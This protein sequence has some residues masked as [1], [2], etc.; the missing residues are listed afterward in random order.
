MKKTMIS[1]SA[2]VLT[3]C[4][5]LGAL[6]LSVSAAESYTVTFDYDYNK[7]FAGRM[8]ESG[9]PSANTRVTVCV[10]PDIGY[11][12]DEVYYINSGGTKIMLT[13]GGLAMPGQNNNFSYYFTM[14]AENVT[15]RATFKN[16]S[17]YRVTVQQ[18]D[19]GWVA[20]KGAY[21][22]SEDSLDLVPGTEVYVYLYPKDG[23]VLNSVW[24]ERKSNGQR[25]SVGITSQ[26]HTARFDM[27]PCDVTLKVTYRLAVNNYKLTVNQATGGNVYVDPS[28]DT[29]KEDTYLRAY[30]TE[31]E[32]YRLDSLLVRMNDIFL[33]EVDKVAVWYEFHM[34]S[35]DTTITPIFVERNP[36]EYI[37][38]D[39]NG[40]ILDQKTGYEGRKEPVTDVIP[41][42]EPDGDGEF[43]FDHWEVEHRFFN[44]VYYRPV[45][46]RLVHGAVFRN[47][48]LLETS[49][50]PGDSINIT[51]SLVDLNTE[52]RIARSKMSFILLKDGETIFSRTAPVYAPFEEYPYNI[53]DNFSIPAG[54]EPG[55]YTLSMYYSGDEGEAAYDTEIT[56]LPQTNASI[57]LSSPRQAAEGE[58]FEIEGTVK[59]DSGEPV[60]NATIYVGH[61]NR[62]IYSSAMTDG[63]G[64][65]KRTYTIYDE[66]LATLQA[67]ISNTQYSCETAEAPIYISGGDHNVTVLQTEHGTAHADISSAKCGDIV[68]LTANPKNGYRLKEWEVVSGEIKIENDSF[69]M[70]TQDVE[71]KPVFESNTHT[72][73]IILGNYGNDIT[74]NVPSGERFFNGLDKEGVF[75]TLFEMDTD[76]YI[77]RDLATKPLSEF[78]NEEEFGNDAWEL[79]DTKVND[80]MTVYACFYKKLRNVSLTLTS[81]VAGTNVTVT[82]N[83]DIYIQTPSPV[84][85]PTPDAHCTVSEGSAVW[86]AENYEGGMFEGIFKKGKNYL[87][88]FILSPDFGYWLDES[89][90]VTANGATVVDSSGR[91]SLIVTLSACPI[92]PYVLGDTNLDGKITISDVTAI[93]RHLAEL[94]LFSDEQLVLA[95]T[96]GD[97]IVDINDATHLQ[98]YLAEFDGI[99]LGKQPIA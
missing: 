3:L 18:P 37:W 78:A 62:G 25:I 44:S 35:G 50:Y 34:P 77:F 75:N 53:N 39:D 82:E 88:E 89:T 63:N 49:V 26:Y 4:L 56:V 65:F 74:V 5:L 27:P 92:E 29:F 14:P 61:N 84:I 95:D 94:E 42:R 87:A 96:N 21:T 55:T 60:A 19:N 43:T 70:L 1:I 98:K 23:Y 13:Y 9:N 11:E 48:K 91:M 66:G 16:A 80:D 68:T 52:K 36:I 10:N 83:D 33:V 24:L 46:R 71:I 97:G 51:A 40:N 93:Q 47:V 58:A 17:K 67:K 86:Y 81:P 20:I 85:T 57:T 64:I 30:V 15:V 76:E 31:K 7:G 69:V 59:T 22:Y 38:L 54:T 45:F 2:I 6:P 90:V 8:G 72:V 79:L 73:T 32:G 12:V 41:E 28:G 99:V